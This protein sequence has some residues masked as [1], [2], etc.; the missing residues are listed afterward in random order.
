VQAGQAVLNKIIMEQKIALETGQTE[1]ETACSEVE[2]ALLK[3]DKADFREG[4]IF[5]LLERL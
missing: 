1:L 2:Q 5:W 4:K 3:Q